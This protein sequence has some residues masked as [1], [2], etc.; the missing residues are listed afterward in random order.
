MFELADRL[1]GI[2]KTFDMT[3]SVTINPKRFIGP[4]SSSVEDDNSTVANVEKV[5]KGTKGEPLS[6]ATNRLVVK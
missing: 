3:K 2:Y 1:V 4:S 6:D 5:G